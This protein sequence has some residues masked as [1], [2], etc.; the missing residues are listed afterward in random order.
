[1]RDS[2]IRPATP[3]RGTQLAVVMCQVQHLLG[4][5]RRLNDTP[6]LDRT[7]VLDQFPDG[8]EQIRGKLG[9]SASTIPFIQQTG[10]HLRIPPVLPRNQSDQCSNDFSRFGFLFMQLQ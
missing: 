10:T 2:S 3:E 7:L 5:I 8:V 6:N 1:M 4:Q 9:T